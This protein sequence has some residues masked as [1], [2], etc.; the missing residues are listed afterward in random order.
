[1]N[2]QVINWVRVN[3]VE[4]AYLLL[5]VHRLPV[6]LCLIKNNLKPGN[7]HKVESEVR[8]SYNG[9]SE[10]ICYPLKMT[11]NLR[12]KFQWRFLSLL[13]RWLAR[14]HS[15][16]PVVRG[17]QVALWQCY[18]QHNHRANFECDFCEKSLWDTLTNYALIDFLWILITMYQLKH[19]QLWW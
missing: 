15:V 10:G 7:S 5:W 14:N 11:G 1:M 17:I 16:E 12:Q 18:V 9:G 19:M 3:Y 13:L 8:I 6:R 2:L 4:Y